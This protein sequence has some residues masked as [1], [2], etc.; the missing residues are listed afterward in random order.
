MSSIAVFA[1]IGFRGL[2]ILREKRGYKDFHNSA[3]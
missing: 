1:Y 3:S 2:L